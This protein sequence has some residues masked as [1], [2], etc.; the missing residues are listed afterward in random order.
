MLC[1]SYSVHISDNL[2]QTIL[3]LA[4][5][6]ALTAQIDMSELISEIDSELLLI[7]HQAELSME[8][9]LTF[10]LDAVNPRV[11]S[12]EEIIEVRVYL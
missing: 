1:F 4:K 9:V 6:S 3:S 7:A 2:P 5:L 10:G 8:V 12:A 11:L